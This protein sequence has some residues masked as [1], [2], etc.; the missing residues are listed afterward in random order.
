[1]KPK[2]S[3][4]TVN[5]NNL[6]GLKKTVESVKN[7]TYKEF[8][9][10]VIDGNSKDGSA[11]YIQNNKT[12]FDYWVSEPDSGV[13]QAMNK[14]I[15]KA[16]GE[17]LLF[18][19]SGDHFVDY[20]VLENYH[21]NVQDFDLIYFNLKVIEN[22]KPF[23]KSYPDELSFSYFVEDTLPHP[24]TF[25]KKEAFLKTNFYKEEFK[26]VSDWKFF[27]DAVC[28]YN[29]SYK[30][31]AKTLS[32]F[33]IG[34]LSSNPKNQ[35]IKFKE[36]ECVLYGDYSVYMNDIQEVVDYKKTLNNLK[37]SR[38]INLMVKLRF[39]NKF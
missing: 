21:H 36:K 23:I 6:E 24:A 32:V 22:N 10:I 5:Y 12:L 18:L 4:I 13:Y 11:E 38:I 30:R 25:I 31:V 1:L 19:N 26:I 20:K 14:G 3:I 34:G 33:Y 9:Y 8:E 2:I 7:Q 16:S 15:E 29:L 37:N 39:L 27:I 35:S 28:K 17:Y